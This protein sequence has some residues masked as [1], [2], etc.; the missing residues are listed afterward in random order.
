MK[1]LIGIK[2]KQGLGDF[3]HICWML[4][5][6]CNQRCT[7]CRDFN[8]NGDFRWLNYDHVQA[9]LERM[10]AHYKKELYHI[11]FTGG[12][13]TL[14]PDFPK[15]CKFLKA[16][17]CQIGLTTNGSRRLDYWTAIEN[18]FN[19]MCISY[20]AEYAKDD[21]LL[22]LVKRLVNKTR[23]SVRLMM[24][25]EKEYWDRCIA[26]GERLKTLEGC[27]HLFV[28]YVPLQDDFGMGARPTV[29]ADWQNEFFAN[30][31]FFINESAPHMTPPDLGPDVWDFQADYDDGS[32][33]FCRPNELVRRGEVNFK[34]WSCYAGVDMLFINQEGEIF[35]GGC[36]QGGKVAHIFDQNLNFP[37]QPLICKTDFCPCGTDILTKK[38]K[39][40]TAEVSP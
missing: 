35:R 1:K 19:W 16:N 11:S 29:Y 9:F 2:P 28:E 38:F 39:L 15:L 23:L 8:W 5:N 36:R 18:D 10:F 12:E 34:G 20:H 24:H 31:S 30:T 26:F 6:M 7:Y 22:E 13:V 14:W 40:Q 33:E 37:T 25:K 3:L 27:K 17:N 21:H 32:S 4:H